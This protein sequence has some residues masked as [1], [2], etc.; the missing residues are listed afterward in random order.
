MIIHKEG[1][2]EN[3]SNTALIQETKENRMERI[4]FFGNPAWCG[5]FAL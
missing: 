4:R 2:E 1:K 3:Q 5:N